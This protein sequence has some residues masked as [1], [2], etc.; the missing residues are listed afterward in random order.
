ME[1]SDNI[2]TAGLKSKSLIEQLLQVQRLQPAKN[3]GSDIFTNAG[4][5]WHPPGAKGIYGGICIA[6]SLQAAQATVPLSFF[7]HSLHGQFVLAGRADEQLVYQVS[8]VSDGKSFA[9]RTVKVVQQKGE[10]IIFTAIINF[11]RNDTSSRQQRQIRHSESM[12]RGIPEPTSEQECG[13]DWNNASSDRPELPPYLTNKVGIIN[14]DTQSPHEKRIHHWSK[15]SQKIS[16]SSSGRSR[17]VHT[18]LAA[19]AYICDNY[20][21]GTVP[22][23]HSIWDFVKPPLTEFEVGSRD[24]SQHQH[25]T[26]RHFLVPGSDEEVTFQ[27]MGQ[28]T[29]D[30][31]DNEHQSRPRVGMMVT[32]SHTMF[33]HAPKAVRADEWMLMELASHWAGDG[34]GVATQKIWSREGTLLASCVQEGVV[35]LLDQKEDRATAVEKGPTSR[36]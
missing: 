27:K 8:R 24:P 25:E 22:H 32:L 4:P 31:Q 17:G 2:H 16:S 6:Q 36:L 35:R 21:I 20:F 29:F 10:R 11:T 26:V 9:T 13:T 19:L 5:L 18:H 14:I 34:R 12:P 33:F 23:V 3:G 30:P 1:D 15:A 7:V 28:S